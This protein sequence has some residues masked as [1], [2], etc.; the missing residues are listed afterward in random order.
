MKNQYFA[1]KRD[2]FKYTL[3]LD[4]HEQVSAIEQL[5][6]VLMLTENDSTNEGRFT[7]YGCGK[8][9][10]E[11]Y[12]FLQG[13]LKVESRKVAAIRSLM[14]E[15]KV[16]YLPYKDDEYFTDESRTAYFTELAALRLES[17]IVFFDPDIGLETGTSS[18]MRRCGTEK[19][20]F[21]RELQTVADAIAPTN[22]LVVYQHLQKDSR[23]HERDLR[24]RADKISERLRV[25]QTSYV[26]DGDIAFLVTSHDDEIREQAFGCLR[27]FGDRHH[28]VHLG[29]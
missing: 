23:K 11:L 16:D 12:R 28:D 18:Y 1:D 10:A 24:L 26:T 13:Q 27:G 7:K 15:Q 3:L 14:R 17:A 29:P 25:H 21:Y 5:V 6:S 22:L 9:R 20:L 2:F 4:L 19:Y 8:M